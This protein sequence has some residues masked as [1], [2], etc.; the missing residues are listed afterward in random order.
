MSKRTSRKPPRPGNSDRANPE[1][2]AGAPTEALAQAP[3]GP[4]AAAAAS[5]S[6]AVRPKARVRQ[7]RS[8]GGVV[9][10]RDTET[11]VPLFLLICDSYENWGFPKGHV[12]AGERPVAAA[13]REVEEETGLR[14]LEVRA[15]IDTIDWYFRFRG[16]LIHKVCDFYLMELEP[17]APADTVPQRAEGITACV[18]ATFGDAAKRIS[19]ENARRVLTRA[20]AMVSEP[21]A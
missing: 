21:M 17:G 7:E 14:G 10:R 6:A 4:P 11:R 2:P 5:P 16:R 18:W 1:A 12:E 15:P 20:R 13:R 9:V 19:Y 8:A 3:A